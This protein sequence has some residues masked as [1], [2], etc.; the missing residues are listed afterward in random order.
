MEGC[1]SPG[2]G[3]PAGVEEGAAAALAALAS[4]CVLAR[5]V[6]LWPPDLCPCPPVCRAEFSLPGLASS[7]PRRMLRASG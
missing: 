7:P 5:E 1:S 6:R 4:P 3:S 2:Q